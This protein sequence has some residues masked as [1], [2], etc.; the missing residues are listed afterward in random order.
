MHYTKLSLS[1]IKLWIRAS[2]EIAFLG[3]VSVMKCWLLAL[4]ALFMLNSLE[5]LRFW[6][7]PSARYGKG[8]IH[9]IEKYLVGHTIPYQNFP[10]QTCFGGGAALEFKE[11]F[12]DI[13]ASQMIRNH[14]LASIPSQD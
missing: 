12:H 14:S 1:I 4:F 2:N 11:R 8:R 5:Y 6:L 13:S 10:R 7:E 3:P 9:K